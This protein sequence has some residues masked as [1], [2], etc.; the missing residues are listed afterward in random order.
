[1]TGKKHIASDYQ[2]IIL[3]DVEKVCISV[4]SPMTLTTQPP[5]GTAD[6]FPQEFQL[7]NSIFQVRRKVCISF[8]YEEYL[9]PIVEYADLYR[10]KSGEDV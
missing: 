5:K 10:A 1:M 8:G 9:G 2:F 4:I 3:L 6:W 7:R